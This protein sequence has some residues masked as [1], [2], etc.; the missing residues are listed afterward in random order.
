MMFMIVVFNLFL[1]ILE[2]VVFDVD[3]LW[4]VFWC[5][6]GVV[7]GKWLWELDCKDVK[8]YKGVLWVLKIFSL[9]VNC[10]ISDGFVC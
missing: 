2:V 9:M 10:W 3:W 8:G 5:I 7:L 4:C 1:V 6:V